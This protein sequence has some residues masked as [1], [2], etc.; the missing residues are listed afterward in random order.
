MLIP[1]TNARSCFLG[2]TF[3][4]A[5]LPFGAAA[6][7]DRAFHYTFIL[8]DDYVGWIEINYSLSGATKMTF[9]NDGA[10]IE[11]PDDGRYHTSSARAIAAPDPVDYFYYRVSRSDSSTCLA[12]IPSSYVLPAPNHGGFDLSIGRGGRLWFFWIGPP[13]LRAKVPLASGERPSPTS[14]D[15]GGSSYYALLR[16]R[17][18]PGRMNLGSFP[19]FSLRHV[20]PD[21]CQ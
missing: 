13:E 18:T 19:N 7:R 3:L 11:I 12:P 10:T 4:L 17:P 8:P 16:S 9:T 20:G 15:E 1:L 2:L 21:Q 14:D 5:W 6:K